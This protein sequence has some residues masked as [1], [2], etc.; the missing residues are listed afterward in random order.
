MLGA[1][2]APEGGTTAPG[3]NCAGAA[4]VPVGA[5]AELQL[6]AGTARGAG[7]GTA[8]GRLRWVSVGRPLAA[9]RPGV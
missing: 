9:R 1:F 3:R 7:F 6:P 4:R 2:G 8:A 5:M